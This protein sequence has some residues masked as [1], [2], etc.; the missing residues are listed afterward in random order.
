MD[1]FLET[2]EL[3]KITQEETENL[4]RPII[5]KEINSVIKNLPKRK[6]PRPDGFTSERFQSFQAELIIN[7]SQILPKIE[8]ETLSNNSIRPA[9]N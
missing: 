7:P 1:K 8:E 6:S 2:H 4:K 9:L 3:P 5:S